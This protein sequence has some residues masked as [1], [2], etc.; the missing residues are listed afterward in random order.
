MKSSLEQ[1]NNL[2]PDDVRLDD[3]QTSLVVVVY[4][5]RMFPSNICVLNPFVK[6]IDGVGSENRDDQLV[7]LQV[8]IECQRSR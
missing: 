7:L 1:V 8:G 6:G 5:T 2:A 4:D 3:T